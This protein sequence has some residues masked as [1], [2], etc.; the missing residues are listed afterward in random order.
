MLLG[1][2]NDFLLGLEG[3]FVDEKVTKFQLRLKLVLSYGN[4]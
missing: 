3:V 2:E 4:V 1:S